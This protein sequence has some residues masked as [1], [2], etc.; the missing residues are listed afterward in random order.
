LS[1]RPK[2]W[3]QLARSPRSELERLTD[4]S[5]AR[6]IREELYPFS[7]HFRSRLEA[8]GIRGGRISGLADL[9]QVPPMTRAE[10]LVW[11]KD[12]REAPLLSPSPK[13][14]RESWPFMRKLALSLAGRRAHAILMR[15][16]APCMRLIAPGQGG[17][18]ELALSQ[19]DIEALGEAGARLEDVADFGTPDVPLINAHAAAE[20]VAYWQTVLGALRSGRRS[21]HVGADGTAAALGIVKDRAGVLAA[22][23]ATA[24][25]T[26]RAAQENGLKLDSL[27]LLSIAR[28]WSEKALT[29]FE[30]EELLR[31]FRAVGAGQVQLLT[32]LVCDEARMSFSE[33]PGPATGYHLSPDLVAAEVDQ[34]TSRSEANAGEGGEV[35]V[36]TL[37]GRG[38]ALLRYRTGLYAPGGL[39]REPCPHCGRTLPRIPSSSEPIA[40]HA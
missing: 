26:A 28:S 37:A 11:Q 7:T 18:L 14:I 10:W 36:T 29:D 19:S 1:N 12:K 8:A 2:S 21:S 22:S 20:R 5:L 16:Y 23:L 4:A 35:L 31:A 3:E 30:R 33:C 40:V 17:D 27:R 15:S 32:A 6:A 9:R 25:D 39:S 24:R 13:G 34:P 38:T